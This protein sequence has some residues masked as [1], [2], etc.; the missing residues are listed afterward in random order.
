MD[1]IIII[2]TIYMR[3]TPTIALRLAEPIC[4]KI[5]ISSSAKR[6][7]N[8]ISKECIINKD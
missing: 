5:S 7:V 1:I 4:A 3:P 6:N 8:P 2:V